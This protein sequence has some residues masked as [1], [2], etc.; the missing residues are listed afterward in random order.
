MRSAF[1]LLFLTLSLAACNTQTAQE[2]AT[3]ATI[4]TK[5]PPDNT[6]VAEGA[7]DPD[8]SENAPATASPALGTHANQR[9]RNVKAQKIAENTYRI[10]GEGQIFEAN[11]GWVVEDGHNELANGFQMTS[12]GAPEW[13]S[14]SFDVKVAKDRP[15]S[16][17]HLVLYETSAKDGSRQH[18]L[19]VPLP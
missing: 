11:F 12:A 16:T 5:M 6:A 15:N 19:P 9:F 2:K 8:P 4:E 13:G 10:T 17:L 7:A 14:F 3:P 1:P 18:E